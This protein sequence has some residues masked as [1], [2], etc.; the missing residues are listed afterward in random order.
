MRHAAAGH[1]NNPDGRIIAPPCAW[2]LRWPRGGWL[3]VDE[4]F[5]DATPG[6]SVAGRASASGQWRR[7]V[8]LRSFGKF[9]GLAGLRLG[10]VLG[11]DEI[12]APAGLAGRLAA[13]RGGAGA[14]HGGLSRSAWSA[15]P[16]AIWPAGGAHGCCWGAMAAR[17][18]PAPHF[19]LIAM[20]ARACSR[21]WRATAS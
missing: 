13:G 7:L 3:V 16:G 18:G 8:V 1:P 21:G 9:F 10:F 17:R 20:R 14:W 12:L 4:A 19:R 5:A 2:H 11:P 6:V 15:Q